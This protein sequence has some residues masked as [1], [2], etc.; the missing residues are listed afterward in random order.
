MRAEYRVGRPAKFHGGPGLLVAKDPDEREKKDCEDWVRRSDFYEMEGETLYRDYL[1]RESILITPE[2]Y[3]VYEG[4]ELYTARIGARTAAGHLAVL[5][6]GKVVLEVIPTIGLIKLDIL[7]ADYW[8]SDYDSKSLAPEIHR[9]HTDQARNERILVRL[10]K[11]DEEQ[12]ED[13][14]R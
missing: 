2:A 5:P 8:E 7:K 14:C 13:I 3:P 12:L 10:V 11:L 9:P 1:D 4:T 6:A